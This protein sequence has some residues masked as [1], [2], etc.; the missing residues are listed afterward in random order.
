M[1]SVKPWCTSY[2]LMMR[3]ELWWVQ[4]I[5]STS[6]GSERTTFYGLH[7]INNTYKCINKRRVFWPSF[8]YFSSSSLSGLFKCKFTSPFCKVTSVPRFR[9]SITTYKTE[10]AKISPTPRKTDGSITPVGGIMKLDTNN[11]V[12]IARH[13]Q[14]AILWD[15]VKFSKNLDIFFFI[16]RISTFLNKQNNNKETSWYS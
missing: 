16:L 5:S 10:N 11:A 6:T 1:K 2:L 7:F 12:L 13:I 9:A 4:F 8:F 3:V 14:K 15:F